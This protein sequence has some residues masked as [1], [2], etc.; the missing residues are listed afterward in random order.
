MPMHRIFASVLSVALCGVLTAACGG[1]PD[2]ASTA[3][4]TTGDE[5]DLTRA[6]FAH[7]TTDSDCVATTQAG[8]CPNGR[9]AAVNASDVDAYYAANVCLSKKLCPIAMIHDT[10]VAQCNTTKKRCELIEPTAMACGGFV[11]NPHSCPDGFSCQAS[12]IPDAPGRC[13]ADPAGQMCGGIMG[14]SCPTGYDCVLDG[15]YPDAGG[16][17][18]KVAPL[19]KCATVRCSAGFHCEEKGLNGVTVGA[20]IKN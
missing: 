19:T 3:G 12:Q 18:E 14:L 15:S 1:A 13:V 7:C 10:R 8:C 5:Q 9:L 6:K 2:T 4:E 20:C 17:C 11:I 16:K